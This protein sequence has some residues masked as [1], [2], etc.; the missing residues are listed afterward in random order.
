MPVAWIQDGINLCGDFSI[1]VV[2]I[3]KGKL[4]IHHLAVNQ[5]QALN[6]V[7]TLVGFDG[8]VDESRILCIPGKVLAGN[9][10]VINSYILTIPEA[11]LCQELGVADFNI[12]ASVKGV[13]A[14]KPEAIN[15][16][17]LENSYRSSPP[18]QLHFP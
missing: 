13:I 15:L 17:V 4:C 1:H 3:L 14:E 10:R 8:T 16:D 9:I 18:W 7:Q 2:S 5:F 12:L 11:V 6:V